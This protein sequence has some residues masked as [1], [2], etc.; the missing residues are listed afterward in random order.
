MHDYRLTL[1]AGVLWLMVIVDPSSYFPYVLLAVGILIVATLRHCGLAIV[2]GSVIL[3]G[4]IS[5]S[6]HRYA[7][8]S[9]PLIRA[10]PSDSIMVVA[11]VQSYPEY[12]GEQGS[13]IAQVRSFRRGDYEQGSTQRI[14]ISW[15]NQKVQ[16]GDRIRAHGR[17][18]SAQSSDYVAARLIAQDIDVQS[19]AALPARIRSALGDL[20]ASGPQHLQLVPGIV[21]GDDSQIPAELVTAMRQEGL[22]HITAVSGAHI[23]ILLSVIFLIVGRRR[24]R[25]AAVLSIATLAGLVFLV[26]LEPSVVRAAIMG[27]FVCIAVGMRRPSSAMPLINICIMTVCLLAPQLA[28]R[29]GFQL[30]VCATLAIVLAGPPLSRW[31]ARGMPRAL[32]QILAISLVA[33]L[34]TG[35]IVVRIQPESSV[36]LCLANII[37]S[38]V[39]A[40]ITIFG[41]VAAICAPWAVPVAQLCL[42]VCRCCTAWIYEVVIHLAHLPGSHLP[43]PLA[44]AINAGLVAG[45]CVFIYFDRAWIC[46][47]GAVAGLSVFGVMAVS[48]PDT[49]TVFADDWQIVQ[50]DVGQGSAMLLR[51]KEQIVLVDVG[52]AD[53][54]IGDCV[55]QA[56]VTKLD[57]VI[58]SHFDSDHVRGFEELA[59]ETHIGQVWY[60]PN[61]YP[62][63]NSQWITHLLSSYGIPGREV[64]VGEELADISGEKW[65]RIV[66]PL[67][68]TGDAQSTNDDS[69]VVLAHTAD[70]SV[71]IL[72]DAPAQ[73]QRL[74]RGQVGEVD[75]VVAGHHGARDQSQELADELRAQIT[76]FSVGA[77]NTY[78]HPHPD[79][80]RIWQAPIQQRTDQCSDIVI[81]DTDV[82]SRCP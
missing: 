11:D 50:C 66:G 37:I 19:G 55:N 22:S 77:T 14:R 9:D 20:I 13:A 12:R 7:H 61:M 70:H 71:L 30:S 54:H 53:G 45:I 47:V 6:L 40:P 39:I 62:Y 82:L 36:W 3:A 32:A 78:G 29:I 33:S 65:L 41:M 51:H 44:L 5:G 2:L 58:L 80:L 34:A 38:P 43:T 48:R 69:L 8:D 49:A 26:G 46:A 52:P 56:G 10:I 64:V 24:Y 73:R 60:S 15:F 1:P 16:R 57:L 42:L 17:L 67:V 79:A 28:N 27:V 25:C 4:C 76:I 74:L 75:I 18:I 31:L 59:R 21:L 35:P 68:I 23:S 63:R 81:T 72:A